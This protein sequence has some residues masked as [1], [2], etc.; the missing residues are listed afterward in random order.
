M[1]YF[2]MAPIYILGSNRIMQRQHIVKSFKLIPLASIFFKWPL[3]LKHLSLQIL[4]ELNRAM[5]FTRDDQTNP[6]FRTTCISSFNSPFTQMDMLL[7]VKNAYPFTLF[8]FH[9]EHF[10]KL[11]DYTFLFFS[12]FPTNEIK[13][14][15]FV[16]RS[17]NCKKLGNTA[18]SS[19]WS[20]A[21]L[22]TK[23]AKTAT[24]IHT[25]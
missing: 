9:Q 1:P 11:L 24:Y 20:T 19:V 10:V 13:Q 6:R 25:F 14:K 17:K 21:C 12:I 23:N 7:L 18:T 4:C 15:R 3:Q 22:T 5:Q 8:F 2:E 16:Y